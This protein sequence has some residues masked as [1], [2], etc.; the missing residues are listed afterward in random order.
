MAGAADYIVRLL[1]LARD[2]T[3]PAAQSTTGA[4]GKIE[5]KLNDLMKAYMGYRAIGMVKQ[6]AQ[7]GAQAEVTQASFARMTASVGISTGIL[8]EMKRAAGGTISELELMQA[9]NTSLIGTS[10]EFGRT[11]AAAYPQLIEIARAASMANPALGGTDYMIRSLSIGLKRMSPMILDNLG[12]Q[13]KLGEAN[14][15]YA[16]QLGKTT[17]ELTLEEKQMALLNDTLRAGGILV[18]QIGGVSE[19]SATQMASLG[20]A[21]KEVKVEAGI[22]LSPL[23]TLYSILGK[24]VGV[25]VDYLKAN[26]EVRATFQGFQQQLEAAYKAGLI[27]EEQLRALYIETSRLATQTAITGGSTEDLMKDFYDIAD[28]AGLERAA[29]EKLNEELD[30]NARRRAALGRY[31]QTYEDMA[32]AGKDQIL[33]LADA[34]DK[35]YEK[36]ALVS[37]GM[38]PDDIIRF[39]QAQ[40]G[41]REQ[42]DGG[43][44]S[45]IEYY[46]GLQALIKA[47]PEATS[48][49]ARAAESLLEIDEAAKSA[50][51]RIGILGIGINKFMRVAIAAAGQLPGL[52]AAI[53]DLRDSMGAAA[54]A[55]ILSY[56]GKVPDEMLYLARDAA[57]AWDKEFFDEYLKADKFTRDM[58]LKQRDQYITKDMQLHVDKLDEQEKLDR[59]AAR[60]RDQITKESLRNQERAYD[61]FLSTIGGIIS[62][63]TMPEEWWKDI[64]PREDEWDEPARRA[65]TIVAQGFSSEWIERLTK[66]F[67]S[68]ADAIAEAGDPAVGAAKWIDAFYKG[69]VPEEASI[70]GIIKEYSDIMQE[71]AQK[72]DFVQRIADALKARGVAVEMPI[73]QALVGEKP[74]IEKADW[75]IAP[76]VK[77]P[78][79]DITSTFYSSWTTGMQEKPWAGDIVDIW[80]AS[81]NANKDGFTQLG[82]DISDVLM[83]GVI[84]GMKEIKLLKIVAQAVAPEVWTIIQKWL[85]RTWTRP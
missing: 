13:M 19:T 81:L 52:T 30:E 69:L 21:I 57:A 10:G 79:E 8:D 17:D 37:A 85:D 56:W 20:V 32:R 55:A 28:A 43:G 41:L 39:A 50:E 22:L 14:K 25:V 26:R 51:T 61:E 46:Q 7:L 12:L 5:S 63:P 3:T 75:V 59:E 9:L 76:Q 64:L 48:A 45:L 4:L 40:E 68:L 62:A 84:E 78:V 24:G 47:L 16:A 66:E 71:K 80:T 2:Q 58:M 33:Q 36:L 74:T 70:E 35:F 77:P 53:D 67:P 44:L 83:G 18:E 34:E 31:M 49:G 82:G 65:A 1:F 54:T 60:E 38:A 72:A 42:L 15:K 29:L 6:L 73:V 23:A 27:T 11:M